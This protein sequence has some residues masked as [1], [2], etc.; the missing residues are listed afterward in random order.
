MFILGLY[1]KPTKPAKHLHIK[2]IDKFKDEYKLIKHKKKRNKTKKLF[3]A[4]L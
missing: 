4:P 3:K 1:V 2:V